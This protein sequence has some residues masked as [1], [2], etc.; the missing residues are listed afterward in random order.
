[1]VFE[2]ASHHQLREAGISV[3]LTTYGSIGNEYPL[4]GTQV[5]NAGMNPYIAYPFNYHPKSLDEYRNLLLN[6]GKLDAKCDLQDLD[7]NRH[8]KL[9]KTIEDFLDSGD[10]KYY[11]PEYSIRHTGKEEGLE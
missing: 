3:V 10:Y 4:L 8:H 9:T 1:M 6:L 11:E 2:I 5:V 7:E